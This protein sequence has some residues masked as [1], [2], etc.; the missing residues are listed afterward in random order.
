ML[1]WDHA[2][3]A[4]PSEETRDSDD[5]SPKSNEK[6]NL[7]EETKVP[8]DSFNLNTNK[9]SHSTKF[10][11]N[12]DS[13]KSRGL[14]GKEH[15]SPKLNKTEHSS[16]RNKNTESCRPTPSQSE[17]ADATRIGKFVEKI[18]LLVRESSLSSEEAKSALSRALLRVGTA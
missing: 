14:V 5:S 17:A 3:I 15:H 2:H 1:T 4:N 12:E 8:E 16:N 11:K 9:E 6:M 10:N 18:E 13:S 7:K